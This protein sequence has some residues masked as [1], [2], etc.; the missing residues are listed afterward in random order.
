MFF[1]LNA[2]TRPLASRKTSRGAT[3][4]A[5]RSG[6]SLHAT[7]QAAGAPSA[8]S[9]SFNHPPRY[10]ADGATLGCRRQTRR[11]ALRKTKLCGTP[12]EPKSSPLPRGHA[13]PPTTRLM[14][15]RGAR[16]HNGAALGRRRRTIRPAPRDATIRGPS[17][18]CRN[19]P[20]SRGH[21]IPIFGG[22]DGQA[23]MLA[24][25]RQTR[26]PELAG[27]I[28]PGRAMGGDARHATLFAA[29]KV[30]ARHP[31][32]V[33]SMAWQIDRSHRTSRRPL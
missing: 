19:L 32:R 17:P 23:G 18:N 27:S 4:A 22:T 20:R 3:L 6:A 7:R 26:R 12:P 31:F 28:H 8:G 33:L 16:P 1:S 14:G 30:G 15:R 5:D 10:H 9:Q 24:P 11:P 21:A 13:T 29:H 2:I 25:T